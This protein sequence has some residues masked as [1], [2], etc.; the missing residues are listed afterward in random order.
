[1]SDASIVLYSARDQAS[2]E[3]DL[4][5]ENVESCRSSSLTIVHSQGGEI[6]VR[7]FL[8]LDQLRTLRDLLNEKL[9]P[10]QFRELAQL[11]DDAVH[12]GIEKDLAT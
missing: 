8:T 5:I 9:P 2:F 11:K 10:A 6:K 1:M 12:A 7:H 3:V 4:D